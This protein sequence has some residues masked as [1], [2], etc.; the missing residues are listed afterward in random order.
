M[1]E[2]P[3]SVEAEQAVLGGVLLDRGAW[4]AVSH[5]TAGDFYRSDHQAIY[6]AM[7]SLFEAGRPVDV[8]TVAEQLERGGRLETAGGLA[9]LATIAENTPSAASADAYAAIVQD[10]AARRAIICGVADIQCAAFDASRPVRDGLAEFRARLDGIAERIV[11]I[12][13]RTSLTSMSELLSRET[14]A[15]TWLVSG[16]LPAGGLSLILG[17]PK[18]GKSTLARGLCMAVADSSTWL[19]R[20]CASGPVVHVA[21]EEKVDEVRLHF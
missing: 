12:G 14:D 3:H 2:P 20:E 8:V 9:Y 18:A 19:D 11:P 5:L 15:T 10:R 17:K 6:S 21:L 4:T 1:R 13:P 7:A 16:L